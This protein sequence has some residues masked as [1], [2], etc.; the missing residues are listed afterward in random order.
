MEIVCEYFC[1]FFP[2]VAL[3]MALNVCASVCACRRH[4]DMVLRKCRKG[5]AQPDRTQRIHIYVLA[6]H[7][8]T[9]QICEWCDA[10]YEWTFVKTR[11]NKVAQWC[12]YNDFDS[13]AVKQNM[14]KKKKRKKIN[15]IEW[16]CC[17]LLPFFCFSSLLLMVAVLLLLFCFYSKL[18]VCYC[19]MHFVCL[20]NIF[21][22]QFGLGATIIVSHNELCLKCVSYTEKR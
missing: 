5:P 2:F 7:P 1:T 15:P 10:A 13:G 3:F 16:N 8:C 21:N 11:S 18:L 14:D 6:T 19:I 17:C 9:A 12:P 22:S 20:P 4:R